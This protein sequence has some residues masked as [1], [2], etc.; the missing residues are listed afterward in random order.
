MR[1][2]KG[3]G[4]FFLIVVIAILS[5]GV[6]YRFLPDNLEQ[7]KQLAT[8]GTVIAVTFVLQIIRIVL[9]KR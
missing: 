7:W 3:K 1:K 8:F 5:G 4:M 6:V 2:N 9:K